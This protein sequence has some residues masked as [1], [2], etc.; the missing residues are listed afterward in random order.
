VRTALLSLLGFQLLAQ[1][2]QLAS[3]LIIVQSLAVRDYAVYTLFTAALSMLALIADPG[4]SQLF[5]SVASKFA[6][7]TRR[8]RALA[9]ALVRKSVLG[10]CI[11]IAPVAA[12]FTSSLDAA[13][14]VRLGF[15]ILLL[16]QATLASFERYVVARWNAA[17]ALR[18]FGY[19]QGLSAGIRLVCA[20]AAMSL[21]PRWPLAVSTLIAGSL[22]TLCVSWGL[23]RDR[24]RLGVDP[25]ARQSAGPDVGR[26]FRLLWPLLPGSLYAMLA[27]QLPV[28]LAAKTADLAAVG[29]YGAVSRVGQI[30]LMLGLINSNV[31]NAHLAS[32]HGQRR[33]IARTLGLVCAAY[34]TALTIVALA[35]WA[36]PG[37]WSLVIGAQ[38]GHL[39]SEPFW[40]IA[41]CAASLLQGAMY[42]ASLALETT[43]YQWLHIPG[44]LLAIAAF[45]AVHGWRV[46]SAAEMLQ[47]GL[48]IAAAS[49]VVQTLVVVRTITSPPR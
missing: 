29:E 25:E 47:L 44:G 16:A 24:M 5:V 6:E 8:E 48:V 34:A 31:L 19:L 17:R 9:A 30:I 13:N 21:L 11:A 2:F 49:M 41:I 36:M 40:M 33:A 28:L 15:A 1:A 35:T 14:G 20:V 22:A 4:I 10:L 18:E 23:G 38:Y 27:G 39:G 7:D 37:L 12:Y 46:G 42:F 45:V 26:V 32:L 3:G 43:R